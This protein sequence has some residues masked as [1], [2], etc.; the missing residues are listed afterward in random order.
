[1]HRP[2]VGVIAILA[3][4]AWVVLWM[5]GVHFSGS[6]AMHGGAL[7]MGIFFAALWLALP[8]LERLPPWL[9]AIVVISCA[10]VAIRPK[11]GLVIAPLIVAIWFLRPRGSRKA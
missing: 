4:I 10:V 5:P 3:L 8:Q 2:T 1:M 7:H 6:S 11:L 9:M